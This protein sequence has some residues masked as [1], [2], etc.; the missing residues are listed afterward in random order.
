VG[1]PQSNTQN[2]VSS[3]TWPAV[4][5]VLHLRAASLDVSGC[6]TMSYESISIVRSEEA[7]GGPLHLCPENLCHHRGSPQNFGPTSVQFKGRING[8]LVRKRHQTQHL[9]VYTTLSRTSKSKI[10]KPSSWRHLRDLGNKKSLS[11]SQPFV[12]RQQ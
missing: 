6:N 1:D 12:N 5:Q 4:L 10:P 8:G 11:D 9:E 3:M 2:T 7:L